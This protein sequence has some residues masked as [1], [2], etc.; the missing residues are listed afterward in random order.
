MVEVFVKR[1]RTR[2]SE[3][4]AQGPVSVLTDEKGWAVRAGGGD[5]SFFSCGSGAPPLDAEWPRPSGESLRLPESEPEDDWEP[6]PDR[7]APLMVEGE[8]RGLIESLSR[9][10]GRKLEGARVLHAVLDD[11]ASEASLVN[12][13][14]LDR[15]FGSRLATLRVEAVR[16][17][18]PETRTTLEVAARGAQHLQ[19]RAVVGR[20][21]DVLAVREAGNG[22]PVRERGEMV[23]SPAVGSRLLAALSPLWLGPGAEQRATAL[24]D[25]NNRLGSSELSVVDDG[26][27]AGGALESPIDGEGVPTRRFAIVERGRY[28]QPLVDWREAESRTW[29][30]SGCTRRPGWRDRPRVGISHLHVVPAPEVAPSELISAVA[31]GF[32]W[33]EALGPARV[34][35]GADRFTVEV[36]G[37]EVAQ[38]VAQR[39]IGRAWLCGGIGAFAR[40]VRATARDL[41][42]TPAG[43]GMVGAPTLLVAGLEIRREL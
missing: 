40:G 32:Y 42:F 34:D 5:G 6:G 33:L 1:G 39:S 26:R 35:L 23:L 30:S 36:C 11:G 10:L 21:A 4:G 13:R 20:L 14:G 37:F 24:S 9:D 28:L 43:G 41:A 27:L 12:S 38:G 15:G 31:R 22:A 7:A 16:S 19:P 25:R 17:G 3:L 8:A 2:R 29:R 18:H